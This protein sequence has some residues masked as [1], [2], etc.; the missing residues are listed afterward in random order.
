M[1]LLKDLNQS[2]GKTNTWHAQ[3]AL[4]LQQ[5]M[6]HVVLQLPTFTGVCML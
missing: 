3:Q 2:Q 5:Q 1:L 6:W 4:L